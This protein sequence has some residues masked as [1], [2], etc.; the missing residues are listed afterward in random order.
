MNGLKGCTN[1]LRCLTNVK[2]S[3]HRILIR[4]NHIDSFPEIGIIPVDVTE[5]DTTID[6]RST[7][8]YITKKEKKEVIKKSI[9]LDEKELEE[10]FVRGSGPGGQKINKRMHNVQLTHI[11][12]GISVHCQEQRELSSNRKIA[13]KILA[14]K[15]DHFYHGE[16]GKSKLS[17]KLQKIR[18]KKQKSKSRSKKKYDMD[19]TVATVDTIDKCVDL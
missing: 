8:Q 10:K 7:T 14:V 18:K 16:E 12:S 1:L 13:R 11:P 6:K 15:V 5:N 4:K 19:I 17:L 2:L 9:I 3:C